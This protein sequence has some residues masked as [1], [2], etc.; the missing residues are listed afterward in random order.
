MGRVALAFAVA[1]FAFPLFILLSGIPDAWGG[2]LRVGSATSVGVL[3]LG[4]P[5][6]FLFRCLGWWQPWRF[7]V[8]GSLGGVLYA[9]TF[10]KTDAANLIVFAIVFAAGGAIHALL[11]WFVAAWRNPQLTRPPQYCLP[12]GVTYKTAWRALSSIR[13]KDEDT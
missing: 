3:G 11:F 2:A 13:R 1:V 7:V 8:G 9:L 4:I 12:G 6:F 10:L 5:A